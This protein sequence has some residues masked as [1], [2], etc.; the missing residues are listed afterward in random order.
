ME[1][2]INSLIPTSLVNYSS[3]PTQAS[4]EEYIANTSSPDSLSSLMRNIVYIQF[5]APVENEGET[6]KEKDQ[7]AFLQV[8]Q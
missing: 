3:I 2:P 4:N 7:T 1:A 8:I 6:V 5:S